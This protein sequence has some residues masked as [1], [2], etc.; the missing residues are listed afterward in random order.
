[1]LIAARDDEGRGMDET[2]LRDEAITL[3][4]AGHETTAISLS[5]TLVLLAQNPA[6]RAKLE[7]EVDR[8]L[9]ERSPTM[10]DLPKLPYADAVVRESMRLYP[11]A[12][13]LGREA[14]VEVEVGGQRF[15]KGTNF[16]MVPWTMHRDPRFYT[17]PDA[18][19]PERW[20]EGLAKK[21]PKYA[22]FPFGGG[23][24]LCIGHSFA[25][26]EAILVLVTL[27][28][29]FRADLVPGHEL[30]VQPAITLRPKTGVRVKLSARAREGRAVELTE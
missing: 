2:Q 12:W 23:P 7:Q 17:R 18:F 20:V 8:V 22:Y 1:M 5:W 19:E 6:V 13:S 30:D 4:L 11:P 25:T 29:A 9:G 3:I 24:R 27:T 16:W 28:R 21:I 10:A 14:I 15:P 26:M